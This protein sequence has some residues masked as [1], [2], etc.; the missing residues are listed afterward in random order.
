VDGSL[1]G[2]LEGIEQA[3]GGADGDEPLFAIPAA[4]L[5]RE[6]DGQMVLL[7]L[8]TEQYFGLNEVGA[9]IVTRLIEAPYGAAVAALEGEYDVEPAVLQR[10]IDVL[11][12]QLLAAGLLERTAGH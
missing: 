6:V 9:T 8:E 5:W 7:H 2:N 10:D 1:T 3:R 11:I 12:D 4:V